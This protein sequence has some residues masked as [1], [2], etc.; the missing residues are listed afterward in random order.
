[1]AT[2]WQSLGSITVTASDLSVVVG[3]FSI[4]E[5]D[6]TIWVDVQSESPETPWPWSYGII[7]WQTSFG[8]EFG[9]AKAYT[10]RVGEVVPIGVG[11]Q[12]RS[13]TG[14]II[15]EPRSFNLAWVKKGNPLSLSFSVASGVRS[16][17][18]SGGTGGGVAFPVEGGNWLYQLDTGL[19]QLQL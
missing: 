11:R 15:Y 3:S 18:S 19:V 6:D 14:S 2:D 9:S 4:A 13:R 17:A 8:R 16:V 1:M 7:S 5:G 10:E 12:P